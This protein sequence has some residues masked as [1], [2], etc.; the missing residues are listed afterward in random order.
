[1]A[2]EENADI[3]DELDSLEESPEKAQLDEEVARDADPRAMEK[4]ELDLDDAPFLEAEPED[5]PGST[6]ETVVTE[7]PA[8]EQT[9]VPRATPP[10]WKLISGGGLAF[11]LTAL[12]VL[13]IVARTREPDM[14][15]GPNTGD[16][17]DQAVP[18]SQSVS[19]TFEPFLVEYLQEGR[20]R[21]LHLVFTASAA[22]PLELT[23][24]INQKQ[25][26]LR[27]SV[28][29]YLKDKDLVFLDN[30]DNAETLKQDILQALNRHLD[31]GG[32][33]QLYIIDYMVL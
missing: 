19:L 21:F 31:R 29:R 11:L 15:S 32:F 17:A 25:R 12:I 9:P 13:L 8:A 2:Q 14:S 30:A 18:A 20:T 3:F 27:D 4:V 7:E 1:M 26:L 6:A 16:G 5:D 23:R 33:S 24:E 10:L 22:G 28:Y